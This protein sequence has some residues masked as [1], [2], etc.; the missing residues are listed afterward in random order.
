MLTTTWL[1]GRPFISG[2]PDQFNFSAARN[3]LDR[4]FT[5]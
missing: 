4:I 2:Q 5:V 1:Y 3:V